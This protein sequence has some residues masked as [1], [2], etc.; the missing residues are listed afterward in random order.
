MNCSADSKEDQ[1]KEREAHK[2]FQFQE[3]V[4]QYL[5]CAKYR[6]KAGVDSTINLII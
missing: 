1:A 2:I 5:Y 3:E 4:P 6:K